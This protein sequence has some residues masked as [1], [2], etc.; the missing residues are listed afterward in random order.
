[1][2]T[3]ITTVQLITE[4]IKSVTTVLIPVTGTVLVA[5]INAK[6]KAAH[7]DDED[8][9][10]DA[11]EPKKQHVADQHGVN[12]ELV[13][14]IGTQDVKIQEVN[15]RLSNTQLELDTANTEIADLRRKNKDLQKTIDSL[16]SRIFY[17]EG[18]IKRLV[19][20]DKGDTMDNDF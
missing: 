8:E 17:L 3:D 9:T 15:L 5:Y 20:S 19:D 13:G 7:N 2:E 16:K 18:V 14:F 11:T 6:L 12:K 10:N 1:M 4:T